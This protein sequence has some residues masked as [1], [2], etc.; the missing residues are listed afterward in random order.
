[1]TRT[2]LGFKRET[3]RKFG[4]LAVVAVIIITLFI[5]PWLQ[6]RGLEFVVLVVYAL[7]G[8]VLLWSLL[9]D[10]RYWRATGDG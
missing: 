7:L 8:G 6:Q 2:H 3:V 4:W 1:M 5:D 10:V 9:E